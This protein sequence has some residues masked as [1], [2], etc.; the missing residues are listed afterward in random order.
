MISFDL[1]THAAPA[2][3]LA[4]LRASGGEWRQS[5]IPPALWREG[6]SAVETRVRG[7]LCTLTTTRRW[8]GAG[9]TWPLRAEALVTPHRGGSS[10]QVTVRY[11]VPTPWLPA[12]GA[13]LLVLIGIFVAGSAALFLLAL[14]LLV[15][16]G[17]L[18]AT[19]V[20]S[21]ALTRQADAEAN[22]LVAGIECAV[23]LAEKSSPP[24]APAS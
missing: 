23:M 10:V 15:I 11:V 17:S 24:L 2:A 7:S 19:R 18:I 6:L 16:A 8:F 22:Y 5:R 3:V 12:F 13:G 4:A 21:R 9:H 1:H 14:P 20:A